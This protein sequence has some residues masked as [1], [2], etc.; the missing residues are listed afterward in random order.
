MIKTAKKLLDMYI[1]ENAIL[2][3]S[4]TVAVGDMVIINSSAPQFVTPNGSNTTGIIL[5]MVVGIKNG[6]A[7]GNTYLQKNSV[8]TASDNQTNA[9][10]S[11]DI[12]PTSDQTTYIADLSA[13][14]GTTTNS[15]YFGY[16]TMVSGTA[17]KLL[18]SSYSAGTE[19]QFLS[20]GVVPGSNNLQVVGVW[21]KIA[22][23]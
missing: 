16:F 8:T 7:A 9:Q 22:Q 1:I 19:K 2:S 21:T 3:N 17:G 23:A 5:G 13:A 12:L 14:A 4:I 20:Y 15:Q 11:V 18:E 10:I 6:P